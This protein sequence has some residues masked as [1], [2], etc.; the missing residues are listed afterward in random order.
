MKCI[1]KFELANGHIKFQIWGLIVEYWYISWWRWM[2]AKKPNLR[3][4]RNLAWRMSL[5]SC[6]KREFGYAS[7]VLV[8]LELTEYSIYLLSIDASNLECEYGHFTMPFCNLL[9]H[10]KEMTNI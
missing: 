6:R 5:T 10:S 3:L 8:E 1:F 2:D 9:G 4:V 7:G